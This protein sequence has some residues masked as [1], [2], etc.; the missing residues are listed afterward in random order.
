MRYGS[1]LKSFGVVDHPEGSQATADSSQAGFIIA[2]LEYGMVI[3][4]HL[5]GKKGLTTTHKMHEG[6]AQGGI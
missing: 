4:C 5:T 6:D 1:H 3:Y 2:D